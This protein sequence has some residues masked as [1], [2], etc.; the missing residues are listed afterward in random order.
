M[1]D[2]PAD[3]P[4][5][6]RLEEPADAVV[7]HREEL[8]GAISLEAAGGVLGQDVRGTGVDLVDQRRS[9]GQVA[10]R[11]RRPVTRLGGADRRVEAH[12]ADD[13][14]EVDPARSLALHLVDHVHRPDVHRPRGGAPSGP[15]AE[16]RVR[17]VGS[18]QADV[19][20]R[21]AQGPVTGGVGVG[22]EG[23]DAE[24]RVRQH[25][26]ALATVGPR[27]LSR[28][29]EARD[30]R[31]QPGR[32]GRRTLRAATQRRAHQRAQAEHEGAPA[33]IHG[34]P[35]PLFQVDHGLRT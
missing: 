27:R 16:Q 26:V 22:R 24:G 14:A 35:G 10:G 1:S 17:V 13:P 2:Q 7:G 20:Q 5:P 30:G 8:R 6:G 11:R 3:D 34:S 12:V 29:G 32:R 23:E 18:V 15:P 25:E 31:L 19:D 9:V 21:A 28:G 4:H 33:V